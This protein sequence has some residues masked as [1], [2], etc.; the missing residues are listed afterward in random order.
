MT[1]AELLAEAVAGQVAVGDGEF[2]PVAGAEGGQRAVVQ[3]LN[4]LPLRPVAQQ[5]RT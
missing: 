4:D 2:R 1:T 5:R 3:E